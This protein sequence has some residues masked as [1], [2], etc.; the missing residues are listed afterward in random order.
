VYQKNCRLY[1]NCGRAGF[2]ACEEER[3]V[4][5]W[6]T[7]K[8]MRT[9][10]GG[11]Q[12]AK[13]TMDSRP[14]TVVGQAFQPVRRSGPST[15][16]ER[17]NECG[18]RTA[19]GRPRRAGFPACQGGQTVNEWGTNQRIR[20]RTAGGRQI[21]VGQAFQPVHIFRH[22]R[23]WES[24]LSYSYRDSSF[25]SHSSKRGQRARRRSKPMRST[26]S[27]PCRALR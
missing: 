23:H 14:Q 1:P 22:P 15:N 3:T 9:A 24:V 26:A 27:G 19:D 4:N 5:E 10:D 8:R 18:P 2:P 16:G 25:L 6:G 13:W 20:P 21:A 17:I 7:N 12:T 11:R